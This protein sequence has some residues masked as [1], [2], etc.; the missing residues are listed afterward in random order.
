M[1]LD[2]D[3]DQFY[4]H[5]CLLDM[6]TA[7][8]VAYTLWQF[9]NSHDDWQAKMKEMSQGKGSVQYKCN[10]RYTSDRK[11]PSME[12][13]SEDDAG[14]KMYMSCLQWARRLKGA[15]NTSAYNLFRIECNKRSVKM[16]YIRTG[17]TKDDVFSGNDIDQSFSVEENM[18]VPELDL[19]EADMLPTLG[20]PV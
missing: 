2:E 3:D 15:T 18:G 14:M 11:L 4:S 5:P 10:T 12:E 9:F 1:G 19:D 8:D 13:R 20:V 6:L 17:R 7:S 16:G